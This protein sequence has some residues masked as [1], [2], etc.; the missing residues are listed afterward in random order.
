MVDFI[1]RTG[2]PLVVAI[3]KVVEGLLMDPRIVR[4]K[5]PVDTKAVMAID[6]NL[7]GQIVGST[8]QNGPAWRDFRSGKVNSEIVRSHR[9]SQIPAPDPTERQARPMRAR[10]DSFIFRNLDQ[11]R[12]IKGSVRRD[13]QDDGRLTLQKNNTVC[14]S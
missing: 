8:K 12:L 1:S 10:G 13:W 2:C 11:L 3:Q 4:L 5:S 9:N 7:P 6:R 14:V